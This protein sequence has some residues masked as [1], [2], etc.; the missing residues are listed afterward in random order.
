VGKAF[1]KLG[2]A[3]GGF[4]GCG[5]NVLLKPWVAKSLLFSV[6]CIVEFNAHYNKSIDCF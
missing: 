6:T 3:S 2:Y 4:I 5:G 1:L